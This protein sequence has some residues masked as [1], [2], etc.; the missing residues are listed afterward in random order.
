MHA[1]VGFIVRRSMVYRRAILFIRFVETVVDSVTQQFR[2]NAFDFV[3]TLKFAGIAF[4]A[5]V[6]LLIIASII[7]CS[8]IFLIVCIETISDAVTKVIVDVN[9]TLQMDN[10]KIIIFLHASLML[11]IPLD[12]RMFH[13]DDTH[14]HSFLR[15]NYLWQKA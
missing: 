7:H 15:P 9:A 2:R 14:G 12:D 11:Y 13:L 10:W 4:D 6:D 1:I 8:A 5:N 3:V